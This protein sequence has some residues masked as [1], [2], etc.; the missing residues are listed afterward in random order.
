MAHQMREEHTGIMEG[1]MFVRLDDSVKEIKGVGEKTAAAFSRL[2]VDTV[3]DLLRYYPR[4]YMTYGEPVEV[5]E[6]QAGSR[7]SVK[8]V[9]SNRAE[10]KKIR[11]LTL[12]I[13]YARDYTGTIK[14]TW[15]NCPFL[16]NF[17]HVGQEF[18]FVG[19]VSYKNGM[20]TMTQPEYYTEQKYGEMTHVWQP[21]YTVTP[22]ITSKAIQKAVKNSFEAVRELRDYLPE[23][24]RSEYGIMETGEAVLGIHFPQNENQLRGAVKRAAFDEFYA[25]IAN[26]HRIKD[27]TAFASNECRIKCDEKVRQFIENLDFRLTDAQMNTVRDMLSDMSSEHA[28]NRLVQGDVGSGKTIVAAVGLYAAAVC[29]YQGV[30]MAPT[31]VLAAQHYK[32]LRKL[33]EP[34][35]IRTGLL[36]GSM[37]AK[38]KRLM[39]EAVS[40]HD[41]DI[42]VGTHALIQD[43]VDYAML[44]LVVTDEQHRFGVRQREKLT[45]KGGHPHTL[46]M[47][48]TPIPRTLA[49]IMY[50]DLDI[51]VIDELPAGR[52]PIKNCVV[53]ES[54][55]RTAQGFIMREVGKGHQ[56][57]IVCPMVEASEVLDSVANVTEYTEELRAS[58]HDTYG[59]EVRVICLHGK[60]KA[61]E[62]NEILE[63]F[64]RGEIDILVST[65][66]IEVG[67]NN[68]NATV[69][70]VENAERFG[71][72]QLHQ[73]RGR[74]GRG[75]LQSY[76]I[77]MSGKK[78]KDTMERLGVLKRS[79]DGFYIAGEDLK[80]RGPG[81]FFGI[82]QSG[83]M[84]FRIGDIYNHADMLRAAQEIY[85]S[86][87]ADIDEGEV[88]SPGAR[89]YNS[90]VL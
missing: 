12:V 3:G 40:S 80:L 82:R 70:M 19:E 16:R 38:E 84:M 77:F 53:D 1:R 20:M 79:N 37:T 22:G 7:Q 58:L 46:V 86:C 59:A 28:M 5:S 67:I 33:Y 60:M 14:L 76:C 49:I 24:V 15:F 2:G 8:A 66:V 61:E 35:G 17:F 32:E 10:I 21:V 87:G 29:G 45:M 73:L 62:K 78:D 57:Y 18:V 88:A 52:I 41:V 34:Y 23:S 48:A 43:S 83:E 51:S 89:V 68:S 30:I 85:R 74:V 56:V 31:E 63:A 90:P 6:L 42:I 9:V 64:S 44:G 69:M 39:R 55:R 81:D 4:T 71:L 54:Y 50:G 26:L 25:F 47:S 72:A 36:T 75:S 13:L 11:G 27:D 65:T